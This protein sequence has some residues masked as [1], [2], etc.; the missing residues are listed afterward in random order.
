V[1]IAGI[2]IL[3]G[4]FFL[5]QA[6]DTLGLEVKKASARVIAREHRETV[7]GY[8]TE[9]INNQPRAVANVTPEMYVLHL[10][11][12]GHRAEAAVSH[13]FYDAV[14]PGDRVQVTFQKRRLTGGL[15]VLEV[16]K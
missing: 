5:F 3:A 10:D 12:D 8:R 16:T 1:Y 6:V 9:I 4:L 11:I 7:M 2:L 15:R 14:Q 13:S